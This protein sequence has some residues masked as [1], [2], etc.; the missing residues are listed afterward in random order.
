MA[1]HPTDQ[2]F[3]KIFAEQAADI[4]AAQEDDEGGS[5]HTDY[6]NTWCIRIPTAGRPEVVRIKRNQRHR[7]FRIGEH[8][9]LFSLRRGHLGLFVNLSFDEEGLLNHREGKA[10]PNS[11]V[12]GLFGDAYIEAIVERDMEWGTPYKYVSVPQELL[13]ECLTSLRRV[14]DTRFSPPCKALEERVMAAVKTI[15]SEGNEG[16][17]FHGMYAGDFKS[18]VNSILLRVMAEETHEHLERFYIPAGLFSG[19]HHWMIVRSREGAWHIVSCVFQRLL[20]TL[21]PC[22]MVLSREFLDGC[23]DHDAPR[24]RCEDYGRQMARLYRRIMEDHAKARA[25]ERLTAVATEERNRRAAEREAR[26]AEEARQA[27][28]RR[29]AQIQAQRDVE[30]PERAYT[31]S[32]PSH[33]EPG[34]RVVERVKRGPEKAG[35]IEEMHQHEADEAEKEA[36]RVAEQE[37][38]AELRRKGDLIGR[39]L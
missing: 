23:V 24:V 39:G 34:R 16:G 4:L 1:S 3:D 37:R 19:G 12:P 18:H 6:E 17:K 27:E 10:P 29:R 15:V 35:K 8:A 30:R 13:E 22:H 26:E 36:R 32:G 33:R 7:S 21:P 5:D 31:A 14:T 28:L 20:A 2:L 38:L 11:L 25:S 9:N